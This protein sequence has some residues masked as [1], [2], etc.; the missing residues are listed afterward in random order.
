MTYVENLHQNDPVNPQYSRAGLPLFLTS[1]V[2]SLD[3]IPVECML[4][5]VKNTVRMDPGM[6]A[7]LPRATQRQ[8]QG[9]PLHS[10]YRA[11]NEIHHPRLSDKAWTVFK[12]N[13]L[14]A[15]C[16]A[17]QDSIGNYNQAVAKEIAA[18]QQPRCTLIFGG[19]WTRGAGLQEQCLQQSELIA[20]W[21]LPALRA[22]VN[23][24][25]AL[26]QDAAATA[27]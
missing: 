18:G 10:G 26:E 16:I 14:N 9:I 12:H 19:G 27:A 20:G 7:A 24:G 6:L 1:I 13:V 25:S 11:A 21:I 4:D 8:L 3:E 23:P 17:A 5:R 15:E 2:K 22:T